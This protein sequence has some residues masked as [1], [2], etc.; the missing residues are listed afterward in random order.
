MSAGSS[1]SANVTVR[2]THLACYEN[3]DAAPEPIGRDPR[4]MRSRNALPA[5]DDRRL[6]ALATGGGSSAEHGK[7]VLRDS[8]DQGRDLPTW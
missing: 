4:F 3:L 6:D 5:R 8:Q 7:Y 2:S 1:S